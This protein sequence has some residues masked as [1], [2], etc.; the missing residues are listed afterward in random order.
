MFVV[1]AADNLTKFLM[2][3]AAGWAFILCFFILADI[4]FRAMNMPLQGT[5]E[6]VANSVVMIVFLQV[7][8]AVRSGSMLRADFLTSALGPNYSRVLIV[9]GLLLGAVFF[10][11]LAKAGVT[12]ALRSFANGEFDGEGA[13]RVPVWPAR[14]TIIFGSA[15]AALNYVLLAIIEVL[16][17]SEELKLQ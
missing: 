13:L 4:I 6:I 3:I 11:F 15:L 12:P 5:K 2:I 10:A 8:F 7:G 9:M 1:R 17:K 16:G 14:F